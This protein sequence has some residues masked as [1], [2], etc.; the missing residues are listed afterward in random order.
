MVIM[1]IQS[2]NSGVALIVLIFAITI[3]SVLAASFASFVGVRHKG[4]FY[5]INSYRA[6][7]LANAGMEYTIRCVGDRY[8]IDPNT[9]DLSA[10][11]K[12]VNMEPNTN[13][14]TDSTQ[15]KSYS[16]ADGKFYLSYYLNPDDPDNFNSNKVLYS[17]G[18][19]G[20]TGGE[21]RRFVKIRR[22]LAYASPLSNNSGRLK[23][24]PG[25]VPTPWD[26]NFVVVP[27]INVYDTAITINSITLTADTAKPLVKV[28]LNNTATSSGT[29]P[30]YSSA[31]DLLYQPCNFTPC[32]GTCVD[33]PCKN[34][35]N[36]LII[37]ATTWPITAPGITF[38][39]SI[40]SIPS[41]AIRWIY[42]E[43]ASGTPLSGTYVLTIN[44]AGPESTTITFSI[45]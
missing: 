21:T 39:A 19:Y 17:V 6:L 32:A 11:F 42:L 18:E 41:Y 43:F 27:L 28:Y 25:N 34:V 31:P 20:P 40:N 22:F 9:T 36:N 33:P 14:L 26:S 24:V 44:W 29:I 30:T 16:F 8:T 15:W 1:K 37:P 4:V 38:S 45:L 35:S 12:V 2:N 13:Q 7:N 10:C 5:Q 3:L 23:L